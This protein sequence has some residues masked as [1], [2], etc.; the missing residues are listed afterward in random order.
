M[1]TASVALLVVS[2]GIHQFFSASACGSAPDSPYE[3]IWNTPSE[4]VYGTMPLGNGEV[5]INAWIDK[6]GDLRFYIARIDSID[7]NGRILKIGLVRIRV[8]DG[9]EQ[10]TTDHF[11]QKL[12]ARRGVLEAEFG[13]D[14]E[15]V[16][17]RLWVDAHRP[18][19]VVE[20]TVPEPVE[21]SAHTELWRTEQVKIP[22]AEPGDLNSPDRAP[23]RI[24]GR[25][26]ETIVEPDMILSS[27]QSEIGWY[28]RNIHSVPYER[29]AAIQGTDTF[30]REDPI[31]H[32]TFGCLVSCTRPARVDNLTLKSTSG[33]THRFEI[34]AL[35]QHPATEQEWLSIA[36]ETLNAAQGISVESRWQEHELWWSDFW[37]RSWIHITPTKKSVT[38]ARELF[39][40]NDY[41][42]KV[43]EDQ[44]SSSQ[45]SGDIERFSL[46]H[47]VLDHELIARCA[48]T[49]PKEL[50]ENQKPLFAMTERAPLTIA[51]SSGWSFPDGFTMEAWVRPSR[52][53]RH[54]RIADKVTPGKGDGFLWDTT[55]KGGL[56]VILGRSTYEVAGLLTADQL[57]HVAVTISSRGSVVFYVDGVNVNNPDP[58]L[59]F[60]DAFILTR[61]YTLQRYMTACAGRGHYPIKFN[62]SLF[63]VPEAGKPGNADY[64][65]WG[66]GYW[67]QNTRLP[68]YSLHTSGDFDMMAPFFRMY[69]DILPVCKY[70]TEKHLGLLGAYYP[71]MVYFWGDIPPVAY[72]WQPWN[73]REDKL[74]HHPIHKR[75][76][77]G[78]L[79]VAC[80]MLDYYEHCGDEAFLTEKALPFTKEILL[81]FEQYYSV[82]ES[83]VLVMH[84]AQ[85][86]ETWMDCT[87]PMPEVA[88]LH[89]TVR[90]LK[91]LPGKFQTAELRE[92]TG[93]IERKLPPIPLI[94]SPDGK[95]ML[96][97]GEKF[98]RK[99]NIE[100]PEL[101]AVFPFR[102]ISF[103]Q[104][105]CERGLEALKH[106]LHRTAHGWSQ[107]DLFMAYLGDTDGA[108]NYLT[109]RARTKHTTSR[110]PTFW[111]PNHD[112]IPDQ[113]HGGVLTKGVQS[114]V[115]QCD[116]KTIYLFPAWPDDWNCQFKLHAPYRTIIEGRVEEGR[117]VDLTVTPKEREKDVRVLLKEGTRLE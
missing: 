85:A 105:N 83:G 81:F 95:L 106:R 64:R 2:L 115:M 30:E 90:S 117:L 78:G 42:I 7:E 84:P 19:I 24:V 61:A 16:S 66:F 76:W 22:V 94:T 63:T 89:A 73:E 3:V 93:R 91:R 77:V 62:G 114:L 31:L 6:Q 107:D 25:G 54:G 37:N 56:R 110:F 20:A 17:L 103:D 27:L 10:R 11:V 72:G 75:E 51:S 65:R 5:A 52:I 98:A 109:E 39:P 69:F 26:F 55:P 38:L 71:E 29:V 34:A 8:G 70:R 57:H 112:W 113:D 99:T 67:F 28:H 100:N 111:G 96:A 74:Q 82:N 35:T 58:N 88:G 97:P 32:R 9:S 87:N 46:Y 68:Y 47:G 92:F 50:V 108:R 104:S 33:K 53:D 49:K 18:V 79:E 48:Q 14:K 101:Y 102:L 60:S 45:F 80:M 1:R 4:N 43:G 40:Q 12:D 13:K 86:L 21:A 59:S 23:D 116:G 44:R 36:R 41:Q 15:K